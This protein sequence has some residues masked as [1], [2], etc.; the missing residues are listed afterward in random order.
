MDDSELD[1]FGAGCDSS[2]RFVC[3]DNL[4]ALDT[5]GTRRFE[6]YCLAM[7]K[8]SPLQR[9]QIN[10]MNWRNSTYLSYAT[11]R[12]YRFPALYSQYQREYE[13]GVGGETTTRALVRLL[14][15][16]RA[17]VPYYSELL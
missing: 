1:R 8:L 12:G 6:G 11:L 7:E 4:P 10:S 3:G 2:L 14:R 9:L 13:Q 15:H 5:G 17:A 16:C